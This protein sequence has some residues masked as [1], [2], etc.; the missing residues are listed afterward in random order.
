[1]APA[2]LQQEIVGRAAQK[3]ERLLQYSRHTACEDGGQQ[4]GEA[5]AVGQLVERRLLGEVEAAR[6]RCKRDA[7][8]RKLQAELPSCVVRLGAPDCGWAAC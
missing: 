4:G 6:E 5:A 8:L 1:M 3:A 2:C 7:I